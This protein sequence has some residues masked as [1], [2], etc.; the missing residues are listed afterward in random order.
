MTSSSLIMVY[1]QY[2]YTPEGV[3]TLK[4]EEERRRYHTM[5]SGVIAPCSGKLTIL[6]GVSKSGN[7]DHN[8]MKLGQNV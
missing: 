5:P 3:C 6:D 2:E 4:E 7:F 8:F 1:I